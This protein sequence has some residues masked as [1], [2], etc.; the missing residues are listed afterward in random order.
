MRLLDSQRQFLTIISFLIIGTI[1]RLIWAADMEWK[2][3]EIW[4]FEQA[5]KIA[6]GE[7]PL[8]A[9]GI[10]SSIGIPQG[11]LNMW[12]F[13]AIASFSEDPVVM[14]RW[15][16][17]INSLVLWSFFAFILWQITANER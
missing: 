3:E 9:I 12:C 16:G 10:L 14:V 11:G 1:L 2:N 17:G 15:I 8:P 13:A 6:M 7:I 4:T 5:R